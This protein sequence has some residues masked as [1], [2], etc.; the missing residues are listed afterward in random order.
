LCF[1]AKV[2]EGEKSKKRKSEGSE[3]DKGKKKGRPS[4]EELVGTIIKVRKDA[5]K[6]QS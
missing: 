5:T 3:A 6:D 2:E 4:S 1:V